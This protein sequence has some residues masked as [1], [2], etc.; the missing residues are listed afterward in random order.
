MLLHAMVATL[1]AAYR[2]VCELRYGQDLS[3]VETAHRLGISPS[4]VATRLDRAVGMLRSRLD[5]RLSAHVKKSCDR[6]PS[7]QS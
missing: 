3:T 7:R 4:N 5:A 6:W 2:E 1:P